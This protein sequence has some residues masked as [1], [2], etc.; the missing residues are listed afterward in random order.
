M[1]NNE[2]QE[3]LGARFKEHTHSTNEAVWSAIE[4]HLDNEQSDRVGIWFWILNGIAAVA[5]LSMTVRPYY[6]EEGTPQHSSHIIPDE[7]V[8]SVES[9]TVN[10]LDRS[11]ETI[12]GSILKQTG[13]DVNKAS[14]ISTP[15]NSTSSK[16]D[17][18][19]KSLQDVK[20][21]I[22]KD[23][24]AGSTNTFEKSKSSKLK[25]VEV[26]KHVIDSLPTIPYRALDTKSDIS[27]SNT[28]IN[29]KRNFLKTLPVHVGL[30]TS[31][32]YRMRQSDNPSGSSNSAQSW[33][34]HNLANNRH[35]EFSVMLQFDLT[36]RLSASLGFG[37]SY[38][39]FFEDNISAT[40]YSTP[41]TKA[42]DQEIYTIPVQAKYTAFRKGRL[43]FN[44]GLTFQSE[45]GTTN[46]SITSQQDTW[47]SSTAT[48]NSLE[49]TNLFGKYKFRQFALE[50]F[51]Q[52]SFNWSPRIS[53]YLDFGYRHYLKP[54]QL[55]LSSQDKLKFVQ[56]SAGI[57]FRIH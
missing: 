47:T 42:A 3:L 16:T 7:K 12:A 46:Y 53:T 50:P 25:E 37:Y 48:T 28:D 52:V 56:S 21:V 22:S 45:F 31:Y 17:I 51:V 26:K 27:L 29:Q 38:S 35:W 33:E 5:L 1:P 18:T 11:K 20:R 6:I 32:M 24:N 54:N 36:S 23:H 49:S 30:E 4:A 39:S 34:F 43:N 8:N 10:K 2:L 9:E 57:S 15:T 14:H 44:T 55:G 41:S 13:A 40:S 19:H